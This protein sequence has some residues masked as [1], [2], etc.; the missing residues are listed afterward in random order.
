MSIALSR[1]G[2]LY[3]GYRCNL[4]C[5][6]CYYRNLHPQSRDWIPLKDLIKG[7]NSIRF[8]YGN[9]FV[10]L[11]GGEPTLHPQIREIIRYCREIGLLPSIIT[12][13][14][15]L[16]DPEFLKDLHRAGLHDIL[17]SCHG[18]DSTYDYLAGQFGASANQKEALSNIKNL[19]IPWR[20]N[21]ILL[22]EVAD[23]LEE[24]GRVGVEYGVRIVNLI[25][26]NL[27]ESWTEEGLQLHDPRISF[28]Y[29]QMMPKVARFIDKFSR[30]F[31]IN[32]RYVPFCRLKGYEK[33]IYNWRQLPFDP[34]E[35]D[36]N[37][38]KDLKAV[39]PD[40]N[41][42]LEKSKKLLLRN[43]VYDKGPC[44]G[45][46][47]TEI[48]DGHQKLYF[49]RY[50]TKGVSP[51]VGE[52]I[53]DPCH[54]IRHRE[55]LDCFYFV[56]PPST[57]ETQLVPISLEAVANDF[58]VCENRLE[59]HPNGGASTELPLG[60]YQPPLEIEVVISGEA[61][62]VGFSLGQGQDLG[63]RL[64][65]SHVLNL[66]ILNNGEVIP[67]LDGKVDWGRPRDMGNLYVVPPRFVK[68]FYLSI[69]GKQSSFCIHRI[70]LKT[71]KTTNPMVSVLVSC[72]GYSRRLIFLL[73]SLAQQTYRDFDVHVAYLPERDDS[74]WLLSSFGKYYDIRI[75]P[76][77][78]NTLMARSKALIINNLLWR[79]SSPYVLITDADI[80]FP[81][82]ILEDLVSR[83]EDHTSAYR[84]LLDKETTDGI[85][86]GK[87]D[88]ISGYGEILQKNQGKVTK[89]GG[90][91]KPY[92]ED[93]ALG[94]FQWVRGDIARGVG[95]PSRYK[96]FWGSDD[97]FSLQ[98][99]RILNQT[100]VPML[101][102]PV[103]HLD[104]GKPNWCGLQ[105]WEQL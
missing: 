101:D 90:I 83:G 30:E 52:K 11:T 103:L 73:K 102:K 45:C 20:M 99:L 74:G 78:I 47:L 66:Q 38:W 55:K 54:W 21:V 29:D 72:V 97:M 81:R 89:W 46:S 27:L 68:E 71:P 6:F 76:L 18:V 8:L 16:A 41:W 12:N 96:G 59:I 63:Y 105:N 22:E 28:D 69:K 65:G 88:P 79:T 91:L 61:P 49:S 17:F 33:Y 3:L 34:H 86:L 80:V 7:V 84:C 14:S 48:C 37:S 4:S 36:L 19:G 44:E 57:V 35:W 2:V 62:Q 60:Y 75:R 53:E 1:R 93:P 40:H 24:I 67:R 58:K 43:Q 70:I 104:H 94:Y 51:Y 87:V 25:N 92:P 9:Q 10:D 42:Y 77:A 39:D 32:L 100:R 95:Y 5:A 15:Q 98:I 56:G 26:F 82:D 31:E 85:L 23:Q 50:G 13:G 64:N